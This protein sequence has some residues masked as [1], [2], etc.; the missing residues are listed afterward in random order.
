[1]IDAITVKTEQIIDSYFKITG[2]NKA[3]LGID[4]YFKFREVAIKEALGTIE[5]VN[6]VSSEGNDCYSDSK[7]TNYGTT[8]KEAEVSKN[9]IKK[10]E[11][12]DIEDIN[13][14]ERPFVAN[15][16]PAK[17]KVVPI[18]QQEQKT[19]GS[20]AVDILNSIAD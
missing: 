9:Y 7:K 20:R 11:R 17:T 1:M 5:E 10:E 2:N 4:D 19:K 13:N 3:S 6:V 8:N 14:L 16:Q 12:E 15:P 18:P